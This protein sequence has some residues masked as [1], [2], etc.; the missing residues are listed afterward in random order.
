[1][2][3]QR[4]ADWRET[5]QRVAIVQGLLFVI[6]LLILIPSDLFANIFPNRMSPHDSGYD[7]GSLST[8]GYDLLCQQAVKGTASCLT[9]RSRPATTLKSNVISVSTQFTGKVRD[10]ETGHDYF[11]ARYFAGAQ[12]RF[13]NPDEPFA[14]QN[15]SFPQS[16]SLYA[17]GRNNP[18][19]F[20]DLD[21]R[22]CVTLDNGS[23]GDDGQPG[24]ARGA[25]AQLDTSQ[26][27]N[28]HD[29]ESPSPWLLAVATGAQRAERPV[30]AIGI[31]AGVV[32]TGGAIGVGVGAI[33]G[34]GLI[35][36]NI[37]AARVAALSPLLPAAGDKMSQIISRLG[38]G[39]QNPQLALQK[40]T[41][42]R[43]AAVATGTH[44]QGYYIQSGVTIYCVG[45]NFLTVFGQGKILSYVQGATAVGG[46][47]IQR[48]TELGGNRTDDATRL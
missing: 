12:G 34:G 35:S 26:Q 9:A 20:V 22:K 40:L 29:F 10:A 27:V 16:W 47:V 46:S 36:L 13:P 19:R 15:F 21:G 3:C 18:L 48:Y 4:Q 28:V 24:A 6:A 42:L 30:N 2:S 38:V 39:Y 25:D 17:Y 33:G 7:V 31:A 23:K 37:G 1:M 41:G 8:W 43:D 11:G 44:A 14:D 5:E 32:L 45:E